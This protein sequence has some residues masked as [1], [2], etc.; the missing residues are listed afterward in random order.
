[1]V[2][3]TMSTVLELL[4]HITISGRRF[5]LVISV[6]N[7]S[8]LSRSTLMLQS[9]VNKRPP[10]PTPYGSM[11]LPSLAPQALLDVSNPTPFL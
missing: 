9:W 2:S 11:R 5:V 8:F 4:D 10:A 3:S 1:M 7:L 6:G